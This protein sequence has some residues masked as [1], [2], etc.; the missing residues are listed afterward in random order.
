MSPTL[1][2]ITAVSELPSLSLRGAEDAPPY[3]LEESGSFYSKEVVR[4]KDLIDGVKVVHNYGHGGFGY[5]ASFG[6]AETAVSL[7]KEVLQN[8]PQS[9]L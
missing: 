4:E 6:C 1:E 7:V 2:D 9:K 8:K 5:Q 3:T